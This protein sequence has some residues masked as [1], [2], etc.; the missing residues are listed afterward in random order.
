[1]TSEEAPGGDEDHKAHQRLTYRNWLALLRLMAKRGV[2]C[3]GYALFCKETDV[4]TSGVAKFNNSERVCERV[5]EI[6]KSK[7][8]VNVDLR[9]WLPQKR[10]WFVEA[11]GTTKAE[12]FWSLP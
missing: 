4:R 7:A 8:Y 3:V 6:C 5:D 11:D 10:R 12:S 9:V 1:V 2:L